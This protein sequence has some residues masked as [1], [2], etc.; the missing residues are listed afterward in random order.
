MSEPKAQLVAPKGNFNLPGINATGVITAT[1]FSGV[2]GVVTNLTGSPDLD[3]G[4]VT[5]SSFVG[6]GTGHAAGLTGTP[7]LNLGIT[8]AT[9]FVG[10]AVGKAAGLTGTPNLNVGL[11]TATSFVGF[12]TGNVTGNISGLAASVTPGVNL[13]VGVCTALEL[14]GDGSALTGA[15][16]SVSIAQEITAT[17]L[18][19]IIDLSDGNLIYYKGQSNTTVGFASTSAAEQITIIRDTNTDFAYNVSYSSGGVT[20]D[21]D[22]YLT[23]NGPGAL[24][25]GTDFTMECWAYIDN[26]TGIQRI[27]STD[28]GTNSDEVTIIRTNSAEWQV[29]IGRNTSSDYW[30]WKGGTVPTTTWTHLAL[31]RNGTTNAFYVNGELQS[32]ATG[33]HDVTITHLQ[34]A[35]GYPTEAFEGR[36]SNARFVNGTALYTGNFVPPDAALTNVTNTYLLCCQSDS[37]TT[38]AA[39]GPTITASGD[40]TAG[41]QTIA[42]SGTNTINATITWPDS[43]KWNDNTVPTLIES[44]KNTSMQ[45]FRFTT[46]DTG[47][48]Y[49]AWEEM[50]YDA[51]FTAGPIFSW[52]RNKFGSVG[53]NEANSGLGGLSSPMQI[54]SAETWTDVGYSQGIKS[55]G[56]L[57]VWGENEYGMGL[58][59][60]TH[61]SSPTQVGTDTTWSNVTSSRQTFMA[62]KTDN[63]LWVWGCNE[64]GGLG[65][66]EGDNSITTGRSS[67]TQIPGSWSLDQIRSIGN[68]EGNMAM[69]ADGTLWGWGTGSTLYNAPDTRSS[70][71]QMP[72]TWTTVGGSSIV[73]AT[74]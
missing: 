15:G 26:T 67:P 70:P 73:A 36:V 57:W 35:R 31:V 18:E 50:G 71:T 9:S 16:S 14:Y 34:I 23:V 43:V 44:D 62:T 2:G 54:G 27:F 5:G 25:T 38:T 60:R 12:V 55:D 47:A 17:S 6:D 56:T 59:D 66:N 4:I 8:T 41:A 30:E 10:D 11:I 1:S 72:G 69:K 61:R 68:G 39:V 28:E 20:F 3:V 37:S 19:T 74:Q 24:G 63:T 48:T 49:N 53:Q 33:S 7:E 45:L 52:G 13:G 65:L 29:Y 22:D 40:P 21:G 64:K 42:V 46:F 51:D 58:N 32:S